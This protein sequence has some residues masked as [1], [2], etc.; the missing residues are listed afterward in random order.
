M[1]AG[2]MNPWAAA[3]VFAGCVF[4]FVF[5]LCS[6]LVAKGRLFESAIVRIV[7]FV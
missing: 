6:Y 3:F 5:L 4:P 1:V 2:A 7:Y